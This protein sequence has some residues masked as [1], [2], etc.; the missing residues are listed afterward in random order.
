MGHVDDSVNIAWTVEV[1]NDDI[2]AAKHLW[3]DAQEAAAPDNDRIARLYDDY[4]RMVIAQAQQIAD[5]FRA[6]RGR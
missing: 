2:R 1:T 6:S 5:D 4:R 3:L